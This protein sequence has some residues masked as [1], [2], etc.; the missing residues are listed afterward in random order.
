MMVL[1][2]RVRQTSIESDLCHTLP[3]NSLDASGTSGFVNDNLTVA[4]LFAAASTQ[5]FGGYR[6]VGIMNSTILLRTAI[7]LTLLV[8]SVLC[9]AH[10][11]TK[12]TEDNWWFNF[13]QAPLIFDRSKYNSDESYFPVGLR[14]RSSK[15]IVNY[16]FGC[17]KHEGK[18]IKISKRF[19]GGSLTDGGYRPKSFWPPFDS[20][21]TNKD[22]AYAR[23]LCKDSKIA[24]VWVV[25]DGDG[26]WAAPG[27]VRV[28]RSF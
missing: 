5:P 12:K 21:D 18:E 13:A 8:L 9:L 24:V 2:G 17:V 19:W 6:Q 28:K 22:E 25:F 10:K 11:P 16:D 7:P 4:R 20:K 27:V 3:N 26:Y 14:N 23:S 1:G 15:Y